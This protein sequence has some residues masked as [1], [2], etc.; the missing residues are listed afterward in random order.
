MISS[1]CPDFN[2]SW[3]EKTAAF[4]QEMV[5]LGG[6]KTGGVLKSFRGETGDME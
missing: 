2:Y 6:G 1:R 4:L 5:G 3:G